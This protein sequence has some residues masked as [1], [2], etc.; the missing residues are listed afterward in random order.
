MR[1]QATASSL[2]SSLSSAQEPACRV[3]GLWLRDRSS[4]RLH[5]EGGGGGFHQ[6]RLSAF[7]THW[8]HLPLARPALAAP[9]TPQA[10][11]CPYLIRKPDCAS[12][13]SHQKLEGHS[14]HFPLGRHEG[15]APSQIR[16]GTGI[17]AHGLTNMRIVSFPACCT[18]DC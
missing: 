17:S 12:A 5:R 11:G 4:V 16:S 2:N 13:H 15:T 8:A 7:Q 3:Q 14:L 10:A 6:E 1:A 18:L 9:A